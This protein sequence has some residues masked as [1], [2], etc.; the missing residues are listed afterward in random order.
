MKSTD[1]KIGSILSF[2]KLSDEYYTTS[3]EQVEVISRNHP[4]AN[5]FN[6]RHIDE[7]EFNR[8]FVAMDYQLF[9]NVSELL[10]TLDKVHNNRMTRLL[11]GYNYIRQEIKEH[12]SDEIKNENRIKIF[13]ELKN[14]NKSI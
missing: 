10:E 2:F 3:Y 8:D 9:D 7:K 11:N 6:V 13:N 14:D 1:I 5:E 12:Y 4:F